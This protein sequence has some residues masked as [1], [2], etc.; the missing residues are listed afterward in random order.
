MTLPFTAIH[1]AWA[2]RERAL[3]VA[4]NDE[5]SGSVPSIADGSEATISDVEAKL[6]SLQKGG[7]V[8][9]RSV[10][11]VVLFGFDLRVL[12]DLEKRCEISM[13]ECNEICAN[14]LGYL[15]EV[16]DDTSE[17]VVTAKLK[18]ARRSA[19][20]LIRQGTAYQQIPLISLI[21]VAHFAAC[22]FR[23]GKKQQGM[24]ALF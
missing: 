7:W 15:D 12:F 23:T 3:C 13:L 1:H 11:E 19:Q 14:L 22:N 17:S 4:A 24:V 6:K 8:H 10:H 18:Q 21:P 5:I 16:D 9:K 20:N 2:M